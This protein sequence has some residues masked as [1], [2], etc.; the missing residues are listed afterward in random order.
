[1]GREWGIEKRLYSS[2]RSKISLGFLCFLQL[3]WR[4]GKVKPIL[5]DWRARLRLNPM[6]V[7]IVN[8]AGGLSRIILTEPMGSSAEVGVHRTS[9]GRQS[10][11]SLI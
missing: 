9:Y 11:S 4:K 3:E 7:N 1:M 6:P 10:Y 5:R 8:D 2:L